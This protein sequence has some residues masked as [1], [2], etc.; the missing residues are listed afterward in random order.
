[1]AQDGLDFERADRLD[2]LIGQWYWNDSKH[3][4]FSFRE[5]DLVLITKS[6]VIEFLPSRARH[7]KAEG[8]LLTVDALYFMG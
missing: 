7:L 5:S 6:D 1:M 4:F 2:S 8:N 3:P